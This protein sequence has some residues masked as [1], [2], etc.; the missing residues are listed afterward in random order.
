MSNLKA[1]GR[2]MFEYIPGLDHGLLVEAHRERIRGW[3]QTMWRHASAKREL[4]LELPHGSTGHL[5]IEL[6]ESWASK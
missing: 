1:T 2:L 5:F 6:P 4:T 3:S